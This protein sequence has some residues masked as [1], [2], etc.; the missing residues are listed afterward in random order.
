MVA[1]N[2]SNITANQLNSVMFQDMGADVRNVTTTYHP[3]TN[4][5]VERLNLVI[6][7]FL[8]KYCSQDDQ[9]YWDRFL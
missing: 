9:Q 6:C 4:G 8:S 7:D 2:G 3:Q 5:R 1:D